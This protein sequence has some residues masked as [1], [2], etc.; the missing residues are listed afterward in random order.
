[1]RVTHSTG[2][3]YTMDISANG[4]TVTRDPNNSGFIT[5]GNYTLTA[6]IYHVWNGATYGN[7]LCSML[8]C[9]SRL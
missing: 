4:E 1:M 7:P 8:T 2:S 6:C 3:S 5:V 9:I